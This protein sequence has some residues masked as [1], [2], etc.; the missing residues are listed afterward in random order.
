MGLFTSLAV[1][2][3]LLTLAF[4]LHSLVC[5]LRNY[6]VARKL[7]I[8]VRII[9]VDHINPLWSIVS[10]QVVALLRRLPFGLGDNNITKY[11]Y[12]GFEIPLR[13]KSH[14]EMGDAFVLCS[15]ARNWLYLGN[16]DDITAMLKRNNDFPHDSEL[17]AMLDVFGPNISTAQGADWKKMRKLIASCFIDQNFEIVWRESVS[18]AVDMG[19]YWGSRQSVETVAHDTRTLSL[20][21]M[22]RVGFGKSYEFS[23]HH[24]AKVA[25]EGTSLSYK[26][27]LQT[28]LENSIV[29][30]VMGT[31]FLAKPWLPRY[32]RNLHHACTS[33]QGYMTQLFEAGKM[34][35]SQAVASDR[36]LMNSLVRASHEGTSGSLSEREIYGNLFVLNFAGHDTTAHTFVWVMYFLAANPEVQDWIHEEIQHVLGGRPEPDWNYKADFPRLKRCISVVY[37]SL[38]FYTPVGM[39]KWTAE[40][41]PALQVGDKTLLIPPRTMI[42]PSHASVHSDPRYWGSDSLVWRPSRWIK[43]G[44][45]GPGDIDGEEFI[46]PVRG[47]F[48]PWSDGIRD[49]PG[50]KFSQVE[51]VATLAALF[52]DW[53]VDPVTRQGEDLGDARKRVLRFIEEDTG[54]MLLVQ[55]LHP[56]RCPL[57]WK[58]R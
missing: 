4:T 9:P 58:R 32:L 50:K 11:N 39:A 12:M 17:T 46:S 1:V 14:Q 33:F 38:R 26:D 18:Q 3:P 41:S 13:W 23:G 54:M 37:E 31:K 25:V 29:I 52:R 49:C 42:V 20:N 27:A 57:I 8:P 34:N 55:M 7:G 22:S 51:A 47:T 35:A 48:L 40:G 53:R 16:P 56:E 10:Q 6:L 45:A 5:L 21:V 19:R 24:E 15:P 44:A 30:M 43:P 2:I 28:I 36:N